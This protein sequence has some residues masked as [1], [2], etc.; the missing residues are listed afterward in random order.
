M[1]ELYYQRFWTVTSGPGLGPNQIIAKLLVWVVND[2][3]LPTQ[4]RF[5]GK[6][7]TCLNWAGHQRV[8]LRVHP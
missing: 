1:P 3:V 8:A 4:V 5:D 6:L 2:P 7:P